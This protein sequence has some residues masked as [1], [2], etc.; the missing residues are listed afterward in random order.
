MEVCSR[1]SGLGAGKLG[2]ASPNHVLTVELEIRLE[3]EQ[4][5]AGA[6]AAGCGDPEVPWAVEATL[7][8]LLVAAEHLSAAQ[9]SP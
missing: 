4:I 7:S 8:A 3:R 6:A 5:P 1:C 2:G 9:A